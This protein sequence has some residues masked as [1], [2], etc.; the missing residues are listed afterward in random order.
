MIKIILNPKKVIYFFTMKRLIAITLILFTGCETPVNQEIVS[1][2]GEQILVGRVNWTGLTTAP[3]ADWFIQGYQSYPVDTSSLAGI[4]PGLEDLEI[5]LFL[6]T[7]CSDSQ[8]QVPQFYK[9]L[10]YLHYDLRRLTTIALERQEDKKLVSPQH[11][12]ADW[13]IGFVP[14]IIFIRDGTEL[15][16]ITEYPQQSLEKD[17]ARIITKS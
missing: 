13:G 6:G 2:E 8:T 10:D 4:A 16:R 9:I 7:W 17:M 11:Q 14:T 12:E 3:Y 1:Y 15:G 5:I